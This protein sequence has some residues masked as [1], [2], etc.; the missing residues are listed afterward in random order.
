MPSNSH[1]FNDF[2]LRWEGW[3]GSQSGK[4]YMRWRKGLR[5]RAPTE[6]PFLRSPLLP[7]IIA[8]ENNAYGKARSK[9]NVSPYFPGLAERSLIL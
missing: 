9:M 1:N 8:T 5:A 3:A 4:I 6:R 2:R 7:R